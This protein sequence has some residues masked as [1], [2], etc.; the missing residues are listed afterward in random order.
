MRLTFTEVGPESAEEVLALRSSVAAKLTDQFGRGPWSSTGTVKGVLNAMKSSRVFLARRGRVAVAT[1]RLCARK[2]W[3]I[4]VEYFTPCERPVYLHEM[5]TAPDSQRRGIGRQCVEHARSVARA[6][7]YDSIR[8]DAYD[9][10]A[11]AGGFYA[12]CGFEE[13]GRVKYRGTPLVYFE[14]VL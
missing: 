13:R 14:E 2:P 8:L 11:G 6:A 12:K 5:A 9:A 1:F 7:R 10:P 4:R 3:A